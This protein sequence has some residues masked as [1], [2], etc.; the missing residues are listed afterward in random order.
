M[1][2]RI[3]PPPVGTIEITEVQVKLQDSKALKAFV[4]ITFNDC[5][6]VRGLKVIQGMKRRFVA[7]PGR[8]RR[9][10]TFQ[11]IAHPITRDFRDY[12]ESVVLH[13]YEEEVRRG[14]GKALADEAIDPEA[15]GGERSMVALHPLPAEA[16]VG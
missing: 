2:T 10:E 12:L 4:S 14:N 15:S 6:V 7:M 16:T 13:A 1:A 9:D 11:D 8:R 3:L 5:F